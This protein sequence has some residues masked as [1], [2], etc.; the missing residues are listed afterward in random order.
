[1]T[2]S[3]IKT[4]D[5]DRLDVSVT[6]DSWQILGSRAATLIFLFPAA[7]ARATKRKKACRSD[8]RRFFKCRMQD[9]VVVV[10]N[11][12][13]TLR[14]G[15]NVAFAEI[16]TVRPASSSTTNPAHRPGPAK[17]RAFKLRSDEVLSSAR[18]EISSRLSRATTIPSSPS[19]YA[20][21][22]TPFRLPQ[23]AGQPDLWQQ[24]QRVTLTGVLVPVNSIRLHRTGI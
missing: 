13:R 3:T 10:R 23:L 15:F 19:V 20:N 18:T 24:S 21:E 9:H 1:M 8:E 4:I 6:T 5:L 22:T 12:S 14:F 7:R 11:V 2:R 16:T 17:S